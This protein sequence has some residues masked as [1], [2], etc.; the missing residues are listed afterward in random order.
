MPELEA[1]LRAYG[2][3]LD[4]AD[5]IVADV[6]EAATRPRQRTLIVAI[7][8]A[9]VVAIAASTIAVV[10]TRS[11]DA[12]SPKIITPGSTLP[13]ATPTT[14]PAAVAPGVLAIGDSVMEGAQGSL[15]AAIPGVA[16]DAA[17][18]RQF[19]QA[20]SVITQ[21]AATRALP[22]T[23]VVAL[24]TNGRATT[25]V[26]DAIMRA[27]GKSRVYFVTVRVPR[28]W[29]SEVNTSLRAMPSRWPNAHVIEWHDYS[30]T[31]DDWFV[32]DGF[33]LTAA[34]QQAYASFIAAALEHPATATTDTSALPV[35]DVITKTALAPDPLAIA[36]GEVW[37]ASESST[38]ATTVRL[39]GHDP[40]TAK[41][42]DTI[43]VP[44]PAVFGI[45][46]YGD[47][48]WVAG[49]GDG[50][51]ADTTVSLVD[52]RTK[53]VVFT[54]TLTG[55]PCAC[56]IVAGAAG[57]WLVGNGSPW[58]FHLSPIDGHVFGRV[59]FSNHGST[60]AIEV[61]ARLVVGLDDGA[62]DV[63]DPAA[64]QIEH[65]I[66]RPVIGD[67]PVEKVVAMSP[68]SI[69]AVGSD[70][71]V[72]GFVVRANS[73]TSVLYEAGW[74]LNDIGA[75]DMSP[76]T[77]V[78]AS[79]VMWLFGQNRLEVASTHAVVSNEFVYDAGRARFDRL[80]K[81]SS[82]V[83]GG[84]FRD[85]VAT[86]DTVWA[87]Y[88]PGAGIGQPTVVVVKAPEPFPFK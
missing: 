9:V 67:P 85:A 24:G 2:S 18:S 31:H 5:A 7:A 13:K 64:N 3:V 14:V 38:G 66:P 10:A 45:A 71:A 21:Y 79:G 62:V 46:G 58:A 33:H 70:P 60:A 81:S 1:Q 83:V 32:Q 65:E 15:E 75:V 87:V 84:G 49:G 8:A 29:E 61:A 55:T 80:T 57:V 23:L 76:T 35:V 26:L 25:E 22:G 72:D 34:G 30:T 42:L 47:S 56:P 37:I 6:I 27:A 28:L 82:L 51:V 48:L 17:R 50:G 59:H 11:G 54:K 74:R 68:A 39:E 43:D 88:D 73:T 19:D 12:R 63:I 44:Q 4:R 16:V 77:V 86:D 41:L 78:E 20:V 40:S 53:K 69:P 52:V 36:G